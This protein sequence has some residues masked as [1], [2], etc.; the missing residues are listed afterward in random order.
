MN[1]LK[2]RRALI[3]GGTTGIE[4]ETAREFGGDGRLAT[5]TQR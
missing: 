2:G 3:T 4:L 1:R 5:E